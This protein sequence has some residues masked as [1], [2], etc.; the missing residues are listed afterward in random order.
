MAP[1]GSVERSSASAAA[2]WIYLGLLAGCAS[3]PVPP[4]TPGVAA[5]TKR[6]GMADDSAQLDVV[7]AGDTITI[8]VANAA[9]QQ[10]TQTSGIV[11]ARGQLH[12]ATRSDVPVAGLTLEQAEDRVETV[13][14][15]RDRFAQ[16]ELGFAKR[17][18]QQVSVVGA[19]KRPG[20]VELTPA[21]RVADLIAASG[22]LLALTLQHG[23]VTFEWA[24]VERSVV[25]RDGL[26]LPISLREA[27]RATPGHNVR[28][29]AGDLVYVPFA[30]EHTVAVLGQVRQPTVLPYHS[31]LR[32]TE[33]LAAANGVVSRDGDNGDIR[34]V[35]GPADKPVVYQASLAAIAEGEQHD[36]VLAPGDTVFVEDSF[37]EDMTEVF[38]VILPVFTF[39]VIA[40]SFALII[41]NE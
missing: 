2:L 22:G 13:L 24:D 27:L 16:V 7:R 20:R 10:P 35:R 19:V 29:R 31:G 41:A 15:R 25:L 18:G 38:N 17:T 33:A 1:R 34:I 3:L 6:L 28:L 21:M 36:T 12:V 9:E 40:A 39:G 23:A 14:R 30:A 32:L 26:A 8:T 37:L 11:D 5:A 4:A